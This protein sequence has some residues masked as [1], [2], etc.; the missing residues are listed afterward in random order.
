M[1]DHVVLAAVLTPLISLAADFGLITS[2]GARQAVG[3]LAVVRGR[4]AFGRSSGATPGAAARPELALVTNFAALGADP[5]HVR[6]V[7]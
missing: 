2:M 6:T 3:T 5:A 4:R 7:R 1:L